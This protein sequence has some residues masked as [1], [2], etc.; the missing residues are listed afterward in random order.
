VAIAVLWAAIATAAPVNIDP[1]AYQGQW[2]VDGVW[3]QG[4]AILDLSPGTHHFVVAYYGGFD[5]VVDASGT[6]STTQTDSATATC[7][8]G[9]EWQWAG[10]PSKFRS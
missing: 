6:V 5:F 4:P 9:W 10:V 7:G 2:R 1:G 3:H 8:A